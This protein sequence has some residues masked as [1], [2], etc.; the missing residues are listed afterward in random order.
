MPR[1]YSKQEMQKI[2]LATHLP[3]SS[4]DIRITQTFP[5]HESTKTT[6]IYTHISKKHL[7]SIKNP[8]DGL[9]V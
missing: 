2:I 5:G 9:D 3:E 4:V 6:G 7:G 8:L 1:V